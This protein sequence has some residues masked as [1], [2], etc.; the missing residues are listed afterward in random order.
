V[1]SVA[2][3][4]ASCDMT[5]TVR[6]GGVTK[7]VTKKEAAT[8]PRG[9]MSKERPRQSMLQELSRPKATMLFCR[10]YVN[11]TPSSL[12]LSRAHETLLSPLSCLTR[13]GL[14]L[15]CSACCVGGIHCVLSCSLPLLLA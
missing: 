5:N 11:H 1:T 3:G 9:S 2:Q 15:A 6:Q 12:S 7:K 4:E 8:V 10:K 14:L 13:D